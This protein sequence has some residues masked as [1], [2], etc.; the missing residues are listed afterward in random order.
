MVL[1]CVL[2]ARQALVEFSE[3][4]AHV[5]QGMLQTMLVTLVNPEVL[6]LPLLHSAFTRLYLY[7][8]GVSFVLIQLSKCRRPDGLC[9]HAT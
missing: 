3:V 9:V 7:G 2:V 1:N 4:G 8:I 6:A 5:L